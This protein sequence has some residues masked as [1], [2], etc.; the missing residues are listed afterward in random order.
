LIKVKLPDGE[1]V[2]VKEEDFDSFRKQYLGEDAEKDEEL[3]TV[4]AD[5][6]A[7]IAAKSGQGMVIS[8]IKKIIVKAVKRNALGLI[9]G[10]ELEVVH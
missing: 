6:S 8:P 2:H 9:Q 1:T 5:L 3:K 4:V 7:Q 10:C